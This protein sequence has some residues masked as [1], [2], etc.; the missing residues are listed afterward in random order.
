MKET[1]LRCALAV[2][3]PTDERCHIAEWSNSDADRDLSIAH[4]RVTPGVTTRWHR[5]VDTAERYVILQ[6]EGR[7]E[8]GTLPPQDVGPGDVVIIPAGCR[9]RI[10]NTGAHDLLFLATCTPRFRAENYQDIDPAPGTSH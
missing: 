3:F 8:V 6:G 9:Q 4:A 5:L 7:V 1:I 10:A 2:E